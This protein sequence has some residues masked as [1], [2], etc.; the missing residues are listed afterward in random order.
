MIVVFGS[1]NVDLLVPVPHLPVAGETVLGGDYTIAPGGKGANQALAARRAGAEVVMVG[2]IGADAFAEIGLS[3]L[4]RD[5]VDLSL[6]AASR[7]PTGCATIAVDPHGENQ[8]A[9][10]VGA[11][12]DIVA[13]QVPDQLLGPE[14]VL[15]LQREVPAGENAALITRA[16]R[17]GAQVVLSLAPARPIAPVQYEDIDIL[18]ANETEAAMLS[19][20]PVAVAQ[21][22]RRA[23]V[24]TRGGAGALTVLADGGRIEVPALAIDPVDTTG[25][26]DTFSGVLAAGLDEGLALEPALRRAS[27]AAGLACLTAGAQS[28]MPDRAAIQAAVAKLQA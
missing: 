22:L 12:M 20:E 27:A 1:I 19:E 9:V 18:V 6:V 10:S 7:R 23:L 24:I 16:R 26:G 11:N 13:A 8:I 3:L 28:G 14:T 17:R 25:A 5:G 4:R 15:V 2:A 21:R